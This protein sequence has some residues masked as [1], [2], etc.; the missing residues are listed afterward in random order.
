[1]EI[2]LPKRDP[3]RIVSLAQWVVTETPFAADEFTSVLAGAKDGLCIE[4]K[5]LEYKHTR[6]QENYYRKWCRQFA[7][8]CGMTPDE[9]HEEILCQSYGSEEVAT[10]FGV[11]RRPLKRSHDAKR[12]DYSHLID[13][14]T[15]VAAE[16]G[17]SVPP[18]A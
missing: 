2:N 7:D 4:V 15:R 18:P 3:Q 11:R 13:T 6:Q 5:P 8:Y 12:G 14:L 9:M 16:M 1:M 17:Y 10:K